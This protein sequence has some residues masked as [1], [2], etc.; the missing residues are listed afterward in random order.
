M[1][2]ATRFGRNASAQKVAAVHGRWPGAGDA[3]ELEL[4]ALAG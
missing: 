1:A 3:V 4:G 2:S